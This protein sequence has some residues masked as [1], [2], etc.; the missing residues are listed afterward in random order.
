MRRFLSR[1]FALSPT[2]EQSLVLRLL[3]QNQALLDRLLEREGVEPIGVVEKV[4]PAQPLG[5]PTIAPLERNRQIESLAMDAASDP[6]LM[7]QA[8]HN[9][10]FNEDWKEVV[11]RAESLMEPS[12]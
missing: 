9:A 4:A 1:L 3:D 6:D 5:S 11:E 8:R 2:F 7:E 12:Y 10:K